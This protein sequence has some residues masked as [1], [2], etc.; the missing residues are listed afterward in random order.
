MV[1]HFMGH[2]PEALGVVSVGIGVYAKLVSD[3]LRTPRLSA[4]QTGEG[5]MTHWRALFG[6]TLWAPSEVVAIP[7]DAVWLVALTRL[8]A[9]NRMPLPAVD[10][11]R[12]LFGGW[13]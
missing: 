10:D 4:A 9:V 7:C 13:R 1:A 12:A 8:W 3:T 6:W 11:F 2:P 5:D